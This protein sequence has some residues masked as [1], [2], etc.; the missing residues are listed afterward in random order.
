MKI[1]KIHANAYT[2]LPVQKN[3]IA[4]ITDKKIKR[5]ITN[6]QNFLLFISC[7]FFINRQVNNLIKKKINKKDLQ[8]KYSEV[9]R[10]KTK[11]SRNIIT[12]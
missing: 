8:N 7:Y 3:T 9:N 11:K 6:F 10:Y 5:E 4:K 12:T 2:S 1:N